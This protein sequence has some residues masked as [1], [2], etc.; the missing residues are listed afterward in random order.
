MR[1]Y[2]AAFILGFR[3][4]WASKPILALVVTF[5]SIIIIVMTSLWHAAIQARG[6]D[7]AG[8]TLNQLTWYIV[9]TEAVVFGVETRRVDDISREI[10]SRAY[11]CEQLLP[12]SVVG[13]R[14]TRMIGESLARS[15]S[16]LVFGIVI[17]ALRVGAPDLVSDV[18]MAMLSGV[19]GLSIIV[20]MI[21]LFAGAA[22][23]LGR[24]RSTWLIFQ[25]LIF[26]PGGMMLP[27]EF[28]PHWFQTIAFS[29]PFW[30][31]AFAPGS[32]LAGHG[33]PIFV[34]I[35][36]GALASTWALCAA[37]HRRGYLRMANA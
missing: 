26:I 9:M 28:Y 18:V 36:L 7:I 23:W 33:S 4:T 35:Q 19:L 3:N 37:V 13:I 1:P 14:V 11:E 24:L 16:V 29:M 20:V 6:S 15:I 27:L 32:I 10:A 2:L 31:V 30:T 17:A 22:F 5:Y 25:K 34:L 12:I 8:Y 21:H